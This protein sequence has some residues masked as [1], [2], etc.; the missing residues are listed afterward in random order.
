MP[1]LKLIGT[2]DPVPPVT[3]IVIRTLRDLKER[4]LFIGY[5]KLNFRI[6]NRSPLAR[7]DRVPIVRIARISFNNGKKNWKDIDLIVGNPGADVTRGEIISMFVTSSE[8]EYN[9][10]VALD[11]YYRPNSYRSHDGIEVAH[12]KVE[13]LKN[14]TTTWHR[15]D[16]LCRK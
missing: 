6:F 7:L 13:N 4:L 8:T 16:S 9:L 10:Y 1:T 5:G 15:V 2:S 11:M 3:H 12:H 14:V